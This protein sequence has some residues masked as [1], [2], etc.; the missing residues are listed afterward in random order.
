M[1]MRMEFILMYHQI[2]NM[3]GNNMVLN[4]LNIKKLF[5]TDLWFRNLT[6][7]QKKEL[8]KLLLTPLD[9][10]NSDYDKSF[11]ITE[12]MEKMD[13]LIDGVYG[14]GCIQAKPESLYYQNEDIHYLNAGDTYTPTILYWKGK[15]RFLCWGDIVE[16]NEALYE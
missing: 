13:K 5:E 2:F 14:V 6:D 16:R 9:F 11:V 4:K 15:F 10:V 7:A 3:R 8:R 1:K 12:R